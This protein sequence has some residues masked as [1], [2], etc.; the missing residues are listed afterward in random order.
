MNSTQVGIFKETDQV[1]FRSF[2]EG[3]NGGCLE[4]EIGLEVLSNL[5]NK[6]LERELAD[7]E[8][9]ALLVPSDLTKSNSSG[10][11]TMRLL[12]S[13]SSGGSALACCLGSKLLAWCLSSG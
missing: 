8:L 1:S 6:S 5:T 11:E 10:S 3:S 12:D 4:P 2:L 13:S 7:E 9:G